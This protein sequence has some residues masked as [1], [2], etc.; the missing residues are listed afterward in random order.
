MLAPPVQRNLPRESGVALAFLCRCRSGPVVLVYGRVGDHGGRAAG[1][2]DADRADRVFIAEAE[3]ERRCVL[4]AE[5]V[6][7]D[8]RVCR[9][10]IIGQDGD[11]RPERRNAA[12]GG[13]VH[14]NPMPTLDGKRISIQDELQVVLP[15]TGTPPHEQQVGTAVAVEVRCP[16]IAAIGL[17]GQAE[18]EGDVREADCRFCRRV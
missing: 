18:Q 15:L 17:F 13:Q 5:R 4:H 14:A 8:V 7:G 1:P 10:A 2:L 11:L 9:R 16:R 12:A 3:V 6:P